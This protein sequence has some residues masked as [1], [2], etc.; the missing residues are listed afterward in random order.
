MQYECPSCFLQ[1]EDQVEPTYKKCSP[2][3]IFCSGKQ[4]EKEL[5]NWQMD[6]INDL[7]QNKINIVFTRFYRYVEKEMKNLA[8]ICDECQK[9]S[10]KDRE[11][12]S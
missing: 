11:R 7:N 1:W 8:E 9:N 2:L 4:T 3:C 6:H 12:T 10:K 5:L